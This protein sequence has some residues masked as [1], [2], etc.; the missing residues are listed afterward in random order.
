MEEELKSLSKSLGGFCNH[1]QSSC[2]AF[3]HSLQR[4]PIPLDSA[5]STFIKGLNRRISTAASELS[6]LES[7]S[8]GTVS[9][10]ELLGHCSQ[11][12]KNNQKD[13]LHLQDR[14]T[15]FGYVPGTL[16]CRL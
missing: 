15:D 10:E 2:D 14:L 7:M 8:F 12:Y 16:F 9:F 4:R 1:L 6:F 5:S 11:I 3:N 13:L